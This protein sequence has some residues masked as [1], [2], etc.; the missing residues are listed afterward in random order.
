MPR[1]CVYVQEFESIPGAPPWAQYNRVWVQ[2]QQVHGPVFDNF[3]NQAAAIA[4][5]R[6]LKAQNP[7][8]TYGTA[9]LD[10]SGLPKTPPDPI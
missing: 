10:S 9:E 2:T 7:D 4:K 8:K 1:Y 3:P 5:A 6:I